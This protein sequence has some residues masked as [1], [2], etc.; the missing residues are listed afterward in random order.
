[1]RLLF[2]LLLITSPAALGASPAGADTLSE[3]AAL[4]AVSVETFGRSIEGR[5]LHLLVVAEPEA[6]ERGAPSVLIICGQHGDEPIA[7]QAALRMIRDLCSASKTE[8]RRRIVTLVVPTANPD[9]MAARQRTNA[10]GVDL[11]R[12]WQDRTQPE[13]R[14]IFDLFLQWRPA[15]II[16]AHE[17]T[18][19]DPYTCHTIETPL[20]AHG[21][22][23]P[24]W[25]V[26]LDQ[27]IST[28]LRACADQ[29]TYVQRTYWGATNDQRLAHRF[30]TTAW[31]TPAILYETMP[32]GT[33]S[34][35]TRITA[36]TTFLF[37]MLA[38]VAASAPAPSPTPPPRPLPPPAPSMWPTHFALASGL[39]FLLLFTHSRGGRQ[40][41][42]R[43]TTRPLCGPRPN[44]HIMPRC[45]REHSLA[46]ARTR[47]L[48]RRAH[49]PEVPRYPRLLAR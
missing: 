8:I 40:M 15:L 46:T 48:S 36:A 32:A 20:L 30:F 37:R 33:A 18:P 28:T 34:N 14:A 43:S 16:D 39:L 24:T 44:G 11:N 49:A 9:G 38:A 45:R 31:N 2:A 4:P 35:A 29:G 19:D 21:R 6:K 17:W 10:A 22:A 42:V 41:V 3:I 7:S 12:D 47:R 26:P 27:W 1:M 5:P 25:S 13:T 23:A